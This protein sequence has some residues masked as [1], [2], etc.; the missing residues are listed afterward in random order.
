MGRTQ[1]SSAAVTHRVLTLAPD[2][3]ASD[4]LSGIHEHQLIHEHQMLLDKGGGGKG[5]EI[6]KCCRPD[7][8]EIFT[9]P[10][11]GEHHINAGI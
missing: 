6:W 9:A 10:T 1:R 2:F 5:Q 4:I 7:P 8:F 11:P 3:P